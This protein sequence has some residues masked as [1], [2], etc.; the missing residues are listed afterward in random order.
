MKLKSTSLALAG[1]VATMLFSCN[2]QPLD[3]AAGQT[4]GDNT[5]SNQYAQGAEQ[6]AVLVKFKKGFAPNV[7]T[8]SQGGALMT[9]MEKVDKATSLVGAQT[10]ERVFP[11]VAKFEH[12]NRRHGLD[13]WYKVT[14]DE[15]V[16]NLNRALSAYGT[17]A[18]IEC[19]EAIHRGVL[20]DDSPSIPVVMDGLMLHS[21][22]GEE[23]EYPFNDPLLKDQWHYDRGAKDVPRNS[24]IYLFDAWRAKA[25]DPRILVAIVDGGVRFD[26][27]DL[28]DNYWINEAELNGTD[29]VDDDGNGYID[30]IYGWNF[31]D[32]NNGIQNT[33]HGTHVAGTVAAVNN[34]GKGG[35]GVAG[36]TGHND[37]VKIV[38]CQILKDG[39]GGGGGA[40]DDNMAKA[41][42]YGADI[43]AVIS[44]N[45]WGFKVSG[46]RS[47]VV[48]DA[49]DYFIAEAGDPELF[50]NS[51]MKGGVVIFAAGNWSSSEEYFPAA[52]GP[53]ITVAGSDHTRMLGS[54]SN[55]GAY[56]DITA[57]GGHLDIQQY[58]VL[59]TD[60][61]T[62]KNGKYTYVYKYGCSM[63]TPH[64][65]GVAALLIAANY[66]ITA[67]EL[68]TK[69]LSSVSSEPFASAG[70]GSGLLDASK[71]LSAKDD[72]R[73]PDAVTDLAVQKNAET[74]ITE[75]QWSVPQESS[76]DRVEK[77]ML[78]YSPDPIMA[79][80]LKNLKPV[81]I[82]DFYWFP[83]G[84]KVSY[85]LSKIAGLNLSSLNYFAVLAV[86]RWGHTSSISNVAKYPSGG[87]S[88]TS[89]LTLSLA[90]VTNLLTVSWVSDF[91][92]DKTINVYDRSAR[93]VMSVTAS[94]T[95]TS[96]A[97]NTS[98]LASGNYTLEVVGDNATKRRTF[99]KL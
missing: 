16:S 36:G 48:E 67:A 81:E 7:I 29:K 45:S 85:D 14:F 49:I 15:S 24:S 28:V 55:S 62:D 11:Y 95:E 73:A 25:G 1:L 20:V 9:G 51:P 96:K 98:K 83:V 68:T 35:G 71:Y 18:E 72:N 65:S 6:G 31:V 84:A 93:K 53:C 61:E 39:N 56:I 50:P 80:D 64:V 26:H 89:D 78:Y 12:K 88:T 8:R 77:Y 13:R 70:S 47:K 74:G 37:G 21:R 97:L 75:V 66:G 41:I 92:G 69:L 10:M 42:K 58:K 5:S 82:T 22:A 59:S 60:S 86:D 99:R 90:I 33:S 79:E 54:Y 38:S 32:M 44:Q 57:P 30:D 63:A 94:S 3:Q 46:Q 17:V 87:G 2:A 27:E 91:S 34:N 43:G 4:P 76:T 52:Y 40:S 23:V 19:V